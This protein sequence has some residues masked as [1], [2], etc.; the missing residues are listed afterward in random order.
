[1]RAIM[2]FNRDRPFG[3]ENNG[4]RPWRPHRIR[5]G[6]TRR[7]FWPGGGSKR[8]LRLRF[9]EAVSR[10]EARLGV[11]LLNRTTRS[12]TPTEAGARLL[13]RLAPAMSRQAEPKS[14]GRKVL[15]P[16][17]IW[18]QPGLL[19]LR[20]QHF[21]RRPADDRHNQVAA[22][23]ASDVSEPHALFGHPLI[24]GSFGTPFK[25][26]PIEMSSIKPVHRGPA[27]EPIT[28]I[29]RNAL[30]THETDEKRNEAV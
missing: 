11:P 3:S 28:H 26:E 20:P 2:G 22:D 29:R 5:R 6:D 10:L 12:I 23:H 13:D 30:L 19:R 27:I 24:P 14:S 9:S 18:H 15:L 1:M 7:R 8:R 17:E 4:D 21:L 25:H 16:I